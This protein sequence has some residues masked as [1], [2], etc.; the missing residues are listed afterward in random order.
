MISVTVTGEIVRRITRDGAEA[1][2]IL[3]V[4]GMLGGSRQGHHLTF[5]PR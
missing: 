2:D 4:T 5:Q 1:G 3:F